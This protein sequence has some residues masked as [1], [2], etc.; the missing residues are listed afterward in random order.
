MAATR[1]RLARVNEIPGLFLREKWRIR[2]RPGSCF[3]A[4]VR[5]AEN[6]A[7]TKKP[8]DRNP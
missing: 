5:D 4:G 1:P 8:T 7:G 2:G 6:L 3:V